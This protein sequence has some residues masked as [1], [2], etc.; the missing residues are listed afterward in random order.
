MKPG[1]GFWPVEPEILGKMGMSMFPELGVNDIGKSIELAAATL[2]DLGL[3]SLN[4]MRAL[5]A[6]AHVS[7]PWQCWLASPLG[8]SC[9][10][11]QSTVPQELGSK[12]PL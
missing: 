9:V 7:W 2:W 8:S 12:L 10:S 1:L 6:L 4:L 5:M 11:W 3:T